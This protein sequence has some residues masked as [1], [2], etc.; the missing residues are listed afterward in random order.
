MEQT[1]RQLSTFSAKPVVFDPD[2]SVI[3]RDLKRIGI[4][5][6]TFFAYGGG[7]AASRRAVI[8]SLQINR[9][10]IV[11]ESEQVGPAQVM[12]IFYD[13]VVLRSG[14]KEEELWLKFNGQGQGLSSATGTVI[15]ASARK[16]GRETNRFGAQMAPNRWVMGR[17]KLLGYYQELLDEPDRLV[18]VFDSF[19]PLYDQSRKITG[20]TVGITGEEDFFPD[21]GLQEGDVV[22]KVNSMDMSSRTRAEYF[23]NEFVKDRVNVFAIDIER[24]GVPQKLIYEVR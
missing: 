1:P 4:L 24:K 5:A 18:K 10:Y 2:Y 21:V 22:R 8:D 23:I 15:V 19:V 12:H 16:T 20:Y 3:K 6:G 7:A 14:D 17:D 13:H 9:Q 11:A